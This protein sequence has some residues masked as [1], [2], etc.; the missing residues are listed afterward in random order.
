MTQDYHHGVRIEEVNESTQTITTLS[1]AI[2]GLDLHRRR[3][4]RG[5]RYVL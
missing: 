5:S 2:I 4:R 3:R 1:T